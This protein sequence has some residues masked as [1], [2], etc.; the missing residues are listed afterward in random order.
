MAICKFYNT[1][2][3]C[4]PPGGE[5]SHEHVLYCTNSLCEGAAAKTHTLKTCGRKGGGGH[6][7][8]IAKQKAKAIA[9]KAVVKETTKPLPSSG[10]SAV[11]EL[12]KAKNAIGEILYKQVQSFLKDDDNAGYKAVMM[13]F[14]ISLPCDRIAG[15]TVGMLLEGLDLSELIQLKDNKPELQNYVVE[16]IEVLHQHELD[17]E[18]EKPVDK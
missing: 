4:A 17:S 18:I 10:E 13:S 12:K 11:A 15:K 3:G 6:E 1:K 9:A 14:P 8:F 5:C 7:A 2:Q 16:A